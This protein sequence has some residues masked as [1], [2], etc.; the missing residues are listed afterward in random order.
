MPPPAPSTARAKRAAPSVL[1]GLTPV[2]RSQL[3][4]TEGQVE[5]LGDEA[6]DGTHFAIEG[7]R[8][9]AVVL[10]TTGDEVEL[11]F[12]WLGVTSEVIPLESGQLREQVG[13]KLRARD[14]CNVLYAMWRIAPSAGIVVQFKS[15]PNAHESS[16]CGNA[17]Y[18]TVR[19]RFMEPLELLSPGD[20]HALRARI[21]T[22]VLTVYADEQR[23]WEG[24]LPGEALGLQGPAGMRTDN[25][26]VRFELLVPQ[27]TS[28]TSRR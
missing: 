5:S 18:T 7:P 24:V 12:T 4:V 11:R 15:N 25:A 17:G 9:R 23:V 2:T 6:P 14:G 26:R 22:N 21:D 16:E 27:T 3:H 10:E 8:Q 28:P 1:N 13:L 20:S 19:P